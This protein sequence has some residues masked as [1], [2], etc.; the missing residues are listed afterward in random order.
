MDEM[1]RLL[2]YTSFSNKVRYMQGFRGYP[3][4]QLFIVS[5]LVDW[6]SAEEKF[7]AIIIDQGFTLTDQKMLEIRKLVAKYSGPVFVVNQN[8]LAAEKL[9]SDLPIPVFTFLPADGN[10][11]ARI[12]E[13]LKPAK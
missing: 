4:L 12:I 2:I 11:F 6:P 7:T 8:Y 3:D 9:L 10:V 5:S 1:R 13:L